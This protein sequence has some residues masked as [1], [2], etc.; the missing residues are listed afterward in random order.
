M[1]MDLK[2]CLEYNAY[3]PIDFVIHRGR[4]MTDIEART[5]INYGLANG[6][7]SLSEIPDEVADAVCEHGNNKYKEF[8]PEEQP[9]YV[10]ESHIREVLEAYSGEELDSDTINEI[11]ER[12]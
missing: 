3:Y 12:L 1:D 9:N 2:G 7:K 8:E 10:S 5:V 4:T 6:L 11:M